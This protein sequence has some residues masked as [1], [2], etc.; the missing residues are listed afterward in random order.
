[1]DRNGDLL[2]NSNG[3]RA[4]S[5]TVTHSCQVPG[6]PMQYYLFTVGADG[7]P[8][9]HLIDL[10]VTAITQGAVLIKNQLLDLGSGNYD[11]GLAVIDDRTSYGRAMLYAVRRVSGQYTL[12]G[13]DL[14]T[15]TQNGG[16]QLAQLAASIT[17]SSLGQHGLLQVSPDG[18]ELAMVSG[19]GSPMGMFMWATANIH[20]YNLSADHTQAT[21]LSTYSEANAAFHY[22]DYSP[23]GQ[24]LYYTKTG[25]TLGSAT[26]QIMRQNLSNAVVSSVSGRGGDIRRTKHG[27]MLVATPAWLY[28]DEAFTISNPNGATPTLNWGNFTG[29]AGRGEAAIGLQP[30]VYELLPAISTR[31]LNQKRYELTDH[32]GNVRAVVS[33][34]KLCDNSALPTPPVA[35]RA[36]VLNQTDFYPFG[37]I[38]RTTTASGGEYRFS[39]NGQEQDN[40]IHGAPGTSM[41]AEFWQYDTRTGRRC[42]LDPITSGSISRF[43]TYH[44][45][46][47]I[48]IDPRGLY[49]TKHAAERQRK[50]AEKAGFSTTEVSKFGSDQYSFNVSNSDEYFTAINE[51]KWNNSFSKW[52]SNSTNKQSVEFK[53][54]ES[55]YSYDDSSFGFESGFQAFSGSGHNRNGQSSHRAGQMLDFGAEGS[56]GSMDFRVNSHTENGDAELFAGGTGEVMSAK[57]SVRMGLMLGHEEKYFGYASEAEAGVYAAKGDLFFGVTVLGMTFKVDLGG[58]IG[59]AHIGGGSSVVYDSET[60][61][62]VIRGFEHLGFGLGE[63]VSGEVQIPVD[64]FLYLQTR[65]NNYSAK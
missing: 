21:F 34:R 61:M 31:S 22:M 35:Y 27:T 26:H 24:Y 51:T 40:E 8:Y 11:R 3:I 57:G 13:L 17:G 29:T 39:F 49:G 12:M 1:M 28:T 50:R 46:P 16:G 44:N 23:A 64:A 2:W 7:K 6:N 45:N 43:A 4:A 60:G 42:N 63:K 38:S 36:E 59:S 10:S 48:Y 52:K 19:S 14:E 25:L 54:Y 53:Q 30:L 18:S 41:T 32:L 47:I 20:R 37:M 33:D 15:F 58:S 62:V 56:M 5:G 9:V 65:F 55:G